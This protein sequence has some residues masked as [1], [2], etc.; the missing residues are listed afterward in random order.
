M[1]LSMREVVKKRMERL[2]SSGRKEEV[3]ACLADSPWDQQILFVP[4]YKAWLEAYLDS[5]C[6]FYDTNVVLFVKIATVE[7]LRRYLQNKNFLTQDAEIELICHLRT[8]GVKTVYLCN[9]ELDEMAK[10]FL[11]AYFNNE[12]LLQVLPFL[13]HN[14]LSDVGQKQLFCKNRLGLIKAYIENGGILLPEFQCQLVKLGVQDLIDAY[15]VRHPMSPE[16]E[17]LLND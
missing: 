13:A 4:E 14:G 10:I 12:E 7:Q 2:L 5:G 3:I 16:A 17:K 1:E 8:E 6:E 15:F 9:M 11:M